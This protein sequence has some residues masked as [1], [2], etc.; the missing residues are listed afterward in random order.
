M[1]TLGAEWDFERWAIRGQ[2]EFYDTEA[3]ID[4]DTISVGASFK[5]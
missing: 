2:Y 5:F 3:T 1:L 4:I